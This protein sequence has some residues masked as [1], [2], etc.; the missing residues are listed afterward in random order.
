V[1][2]CRLQT[3]LDR[4]DSL[5]AGGAD[6]TAVRRALT[7]QLRSWR[8]MNLPLARDVLPD[9]SVRVDTSAP[10]PHR[11][12]LEVRRDEAGFTVYGT[13]IWRNDPWLTEGTVYARDYGPERN[14][15]LRAL[16]PGRLSYRY[17]PVSR[18]PGAE[19]QLSPLPGPGRRIDISGGE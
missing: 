3:T 6:S 7:A 13:L 17:A 18:E 12:Q 2:G 16:Y 5:V 19:P 14:R 4:A 10:L 1:D 15:R 9:Q 8:D 11:C